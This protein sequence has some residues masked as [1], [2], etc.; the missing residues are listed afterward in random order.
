VE[1]VYTV[2]LRIVEGAHRA[3]PILTK[4]NIK[5]LL[6]MKIIVDFTVG[7]CYYI[8]KKKNRAQNVESV[9]KEGAL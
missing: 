4:Q 3:D 7:L 5:I 2:R 8:I 1:I 9:E 6:Q